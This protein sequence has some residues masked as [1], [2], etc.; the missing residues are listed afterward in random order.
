MKKLSIVLLVSLLMGTFT[1]SLKAQTYNVYF[2][3]IHSHSWYSDG[4]QDQN[5]STYTLPVA[6]NMTFAKSSPSTQFL[7]I[8]DHNHVDGGFPMTLALWRSGHHE[9]DS[10][11]QD[12]SF[13]ALYG[14]EWGTTASSGGHTL[15]YGTDKL[16]GWNPGIY[17][18]LVN[19][20]NYTPSTTANLVDSVKKY[21]GFIYLAHP[22]SGDYNGIFSSAYNAKWDSV[23]RGTAMKNGPSTS[24]NTSESDPSTSNYLTQFNTL[25]RIGYH[26]APVANQDNHNTTFCRAN[27]QRTA[28]LATS[29]TKVNIIDGLRNRR[30]YATEDHNLNISYT[31][32]S[33]IM[34]DIFSTNDSI[35]IRIKATDPDVSESISSIQLYYGVPGSGSNPTVMTTVS[36]RDSLVSTFYQTTGTTYYYYAVITEADGNKA[37]TAPMWITTVTGASPGSFALSSPANSSTNQ[38]LAGT[39]SWGSSSSATG[40]DVYLGTTNPP[41]TLVSS[42]QAGTTY[43]YSGLSSTTTYYWKVVAKNGVGSVDATSSPWSFTTTVAVP[44]AFTLVSPSS[45]TTGQAIG[46]VLRWGSSA[47]VTSYDVYLE[48]VNPPTTVVSTSQ[49][50]TF[51]T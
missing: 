29:L 43:N 18:V 22:G 12:G 9:A 47:S 38:A 21:G 3:D 2:G 8:S 32:G 31:V 48:T 46:G 7:G 34:G 51:Y 49:T 42:N 40:Y 44:A 36:S 1:L 13:V 45:G 50:D 5:P 15:I 17:D 24:T 41:T 30:A 35:R 26:V 6:R 28:V 19:K 37:W 20:N 11:N 39:L 25:L 4:N 23:L 16:F 33:H 27:Q 14:Q 10:V